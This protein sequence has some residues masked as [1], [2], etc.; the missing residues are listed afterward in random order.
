[1]IKNQWYAI[2]Q[3]KEIRPNRL[4]TLKRLDRE[5]VLWR[6][7]NG[8]IAC[9]ENKCCHRGASLGLGILTDDH[10]ACP[11]H[12]FVY[13]QTGQVVS[14]PANGKNTPVSH[15]Y[16]VQDFQVVEKQGMIWLWFGDG[17]PNN[18][19]IPCFDELDAFHWITFVDHWPVH[20]SRAIENQ[21]DCVHIP[22]VHHNTIGKGNATL[23]NGPMVVWDDKQMNMYVYNAVDEGQAPLKPDQLKE[24]TSK[25]QLQFKF[26]NTWH[27]NIAPKIRVGTHFAP[28]DASNTV[29]YLRYYHDITSIPGIRHLIA[30]SGWVYSR[31]ILRQD[32]RVV[33]TQKPLKS[34]LKMGEK[35]IQGDLPII[36]YRKRRDALI[37]EDLQNL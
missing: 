22:F 35:L 14:I 21:L 32:K 4:H 27:N 26:P 19:P 31:I 11:F 18:K 34:D 30:W 15:T 2:A 25:S 10:V 13:N 28:V 24:L 16:S 9:I 5:L 23:V 1:M 29:I 33:V 12:G 36:E 20:Y 17:K 3:S 37:K 7:K 8:Q 6:L